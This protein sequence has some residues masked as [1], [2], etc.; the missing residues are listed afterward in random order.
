MSATTA[1]LPSIESDL[2]A[3]YHLTPAQIASYRERGFIKLKEVLSPATLA[4]YGRAIAD[5]VQR[6]NHQH[7]PMAERTTYGKAFLQIMN[8]WETDR[9][10]KEFVFSQKLGRI[11]AE[12]MGVRGVRLYHDQ[13]LFKEPGGGFTPWHCDQFY[14]PLANPNATTVWVPFQ[15]VPLPM[16]PLAFSVGSHRLEIGRDL[17]ISDESEAMMAKA[18][19]TV[20][21]DEGP[22]E[23]GEVS[24]HAGWTFH[25]AGGNTTA[26]MRQVMTVIYIA[27]DMRIAVPK[28]PSQE[29]DLEGWFPGKKPGELADSPINPLVWRG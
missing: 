10:A 8:L 9:V 25:R 21:T 6:R 29:S 23:L 18:L 14:W 12:L 7:V 11:A 19:A 24:Y 26:S 4:H 1:P 15:A 3:H 2:A 5:E 17:Q 16:G 22:F 20:P 13:A 28:N 27:D